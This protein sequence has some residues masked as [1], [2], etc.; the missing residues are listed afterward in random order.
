[1]TRI[2]NAL[3]IGC[4]SLVGAGIVTAAT[5]AALKNALFDVGVWLLISAFA[6]LATL[7]VLILADFLRDYFR[8]RAGLRS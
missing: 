3:N 6:V 7:A 4:A 5:G 8:R 1:M 2:V